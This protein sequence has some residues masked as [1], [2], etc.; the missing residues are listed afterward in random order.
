MRANK[1]LVLLILALGCGLVASIGITQLLAKRNA[2]NAPLNDAETIF[3]AM[4]DIPLGDFLST[5]VLKL[6]PWPKDK[7]PPGALTKA[8]D[9]DGRRTKTKLYAG[10]PI[11]DN[12][13]FLKGVSDQGADAL[14]P[15][16]YR[17]VPVKVDNVSGAAGMI[18]PGSRVDV[19]VYLTRSNE[20]D[21][22]ETTTRTVLQD[23]KVFAI[24]NLVS[25]ESK[26]QDGG[27]SA[28]VTTISLLVTPPQAA[29]LTLASEMG[30]IKLVMRSPE[31][32]QQ[33]NTGHATP[34]EL[35]DKPLAGE[36]KK[37]DLIEKL[38]V[39]KPAQSLT[40]GLLDALRT[41]KTEQPTPAVQP[42]ATWTMRVITPSQINDIVLEAYFDPNNPRDSSQLFWKAQEQPKSL[43]ANAAAVDRH[44]Q[45]QSPLADKPK[46]TK[47]TGQESAVKVKEPLP[48]NAASL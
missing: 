26:E 22:S 35:F 47:E 25:V 40:Q 5:E 31:D 28:P 12:K 38:P 18:M 37:E 11:L 32:D 15:K 19:M 7:V 3:V 10:E 1:S 20:K 43:E 45:A 9:V 21:I 14:I 27:K 24:N 39:E 42:T 33:T 13:L 30:K 17:V 48:T 29:K 36:R 41:A 44:S 34:E 8:E 4:K 6:E 16:G 23:I 46:S 2:E